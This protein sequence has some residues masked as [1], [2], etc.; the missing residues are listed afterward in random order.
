MDKPE[1]NGENMR[2]S[3]YDFLGKVYLTP[4]QR[5]ARYIRMLERWVVILAV[6]F[7]I[8]F[9]VFGITVIL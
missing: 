6:L 8:L 4:G 5:Q 1:R 2:T 9:I 7:V 3:K